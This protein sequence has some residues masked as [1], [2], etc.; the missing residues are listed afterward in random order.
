M[1]KALNHICFSVSNLQ[2][3]IYFYNNVLKA[4]LLVEGNTTAYFDLNGIW[5]AL[6]QEEAIPRK[7]IE[8]S[9]THIAFS[10]EEQEFEEWYHWL[11][12]NNVNILEGRKR[13]TKDKKSIYFTDP[14]GHK[15]ELHTGTL[16]DRLDYYKQD[17]KHMTFY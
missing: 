4:K 2:K 7:E 1:I 9:Y 3:S 5:L 12:Q 16:Q 6:N 14:D 13:D 15:L 10:I 8:Y 11:K 17:K